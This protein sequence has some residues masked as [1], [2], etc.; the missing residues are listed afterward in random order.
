[1]SKSLVLT[2]NCRTDP[3]KV[4]KHNEDACVIRDDIGLWAVADGMGGHHA[5]DVASQTIVDRLAEI[6]AKDSLAD[7][8]DAVE[9]TLDDVNHY[10]MDMARE[11]RQTIGATVIALLSSGDRYAV[12][13][14]AGDSRLYRIRGR[15]IEAL[16]QDHAM[17][18]DL[19]ESG[20]LSREDAENH[21]QADRVTRACGGTDEFYLD[22]EMFE[23]K[24]GDIYIMCSDGLYKELEED[25][26]LEI[27]R[28]TK[29]R[30]TIADAL[31]DKALTRKARD[32]TTV[33]CVE[34]QRG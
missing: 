7:L 25:E 2:S 11:Q 13:L 14:W 16:S 28:E 1:M 20:L 21:P 19:F 17:S 3:G 8:T 4:R 10:L 26:I 31:V 5:G 29:D 22:C 30:N 34:A 24:A 27:V 23:M 33:V 15:K 9:D 6:P 32:N 18:E 12:C